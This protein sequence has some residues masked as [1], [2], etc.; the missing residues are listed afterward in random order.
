MI[1]SHYEKSRSHV[2]PRDLSA[3][4]ARMCMYGAGGRADLMINGPLIKLSRKTCRGKLEARDPL[5]GSRGRATRV[6]NQ[7]EFARLARRGG[8]TRVSKT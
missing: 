7:R 4:K 5:S 2:K 3:R 8:L 6:W 1:S